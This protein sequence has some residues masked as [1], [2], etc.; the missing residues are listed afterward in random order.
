MTYPLNR[1]RLRTPLVA[2]LLAVIPPITTHAIDTI[3]GWDAMDAH[4]NPK[5]PEVVVRNWIPDADNYAWIAYFWVQGYMALAESTGDARYM[6]TAKQILDHMLANRDD[7]RF[8][9]KPLE[10]A[11]VSAP[12]HYLFH[13][14]TPAPGWR[15]RSGFTQN[16]M[17][18][19]VLIDGRI[20]EI[21]LRW[22]DLSRKAFP[23]YEADVTRYLAR[24]HETLELHQDAFH[25]IPANY[26]AS[27]S[28][29][30]PELPAGGY[31]YWWHDKNQNPPDTDTP[32]VYSGQTPVN[33]SAVMAS[34]MLY[35][36]RL[37][38]RNNYR[39]KVQL[40]VNYFLNSLDRAHPEK[41]VW[42][43]DPLNTRRHDIEDIGHAAISL[44]L[45]QNAYL[46]GGFGVTREH[47]LRLTETYLT[48]FDEETG[49]PHRYI[50]GTD[51]EKES[52]D[53][54]YGMR[55]AVC[56]YPWLWFSQ[57]DP[58]VLT[59]AR[60]AFENHFGDKYSSGFSMGGWAALLYW[61]TVRDG[62]AAIID[63][64]KPGK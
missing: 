29:Y 39:E 53:E 48:L 50:D 49:F 60:R 57:F 24:I 34:A 13:T 22:C 15:R 6:D 36:D 54:T 20:S 5:G 40:I 56:Y 43:Y 17:Q 28:I 58:A 14:G 33:H 64:S 2:L 11:Y 30:T 37:T 63:N 42:E 25:Q 12:T 27:P 32:R 59:K 51:A 47:M 9:D 41:A 31:R 52:A 23:Q 8:A 3:P 46:D 4:H 7:I 21:F 62:K 35:Y 38:G 44:P 18:V 10:P 55:S 45:I 61:E 26:D 19:S 16:G 1:I